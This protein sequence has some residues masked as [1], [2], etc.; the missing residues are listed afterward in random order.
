[1]L[2]KVADEIAEHGTVISHPTH[3]GRNVTMLI[4]PLAKKVQTV[5][6]QHRRGRETKDRRAVRQ[7]AHLAAK[8]LD[9]S[10]NKIIDKEKGSGDAKK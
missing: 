4:Q 8:G 2:N 5:S 9:A 1:M 7:A 10:G 6:E 3:E